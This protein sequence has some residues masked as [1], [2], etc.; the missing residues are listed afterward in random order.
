MAGT[1]L[2]YFVIANAP[3]SVLCEDA[4]LATALHTVGVPLHP[5]TPLSVQIAEDGSRL[6]QWLFAEKSACG[7]YKTQDLIEW[8]KNATWHAQNPAHEFAVVARVLRNHAITAGDLRSAVPVLKMVRGSRE[9]Y[10]PENAS[11]ALREFRIG[12]LE[13]RIPMNEEF[14]ESQ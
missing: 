11:P 1:G 8:W 9:V 12:Q 6:W 7:Q 4:L 13:G 2:H 14:S 3:Q 5:E 10:I